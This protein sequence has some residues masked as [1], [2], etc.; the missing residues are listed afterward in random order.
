MDSFVC[1]HHF[2][3]DFKQSRVYYDAVRSLFRLPEVL[4]SAMLLHQ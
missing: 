3:F 1:S 2:S 4:T